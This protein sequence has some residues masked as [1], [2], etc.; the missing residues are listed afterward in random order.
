MK[1][2]LFLLLFAWS[3]LNI[4]AQIAGDWHG[5]LDVKG[6][7]LTIVF[8]FN[9]ENGVYKGTMDSPDQSANGI[10]L[11]SIAFKDSTVNIQIASA[12]AE[13]EGKWDGKL[14]KGNFKQIGMSF[15]LNLEG[16]ALKR[17]RPQEPSAPYPYE[18]EEVTFQNK[19]DS[20]SLAG[21]LTLPKG[22]GQFPSMIM[23]TG[24]G[25]ENRDE[26]IYD[27][28]PFWI[29]ADYLTRKGIAVLRYDDRGFGKSGGAF[30][31]A[32]TS[33]F[34][35]D[36][37]A[38][39]SY[40]KSRK[41]INK[42]KIGLIGHSE[43]GIIASMVASANKKIAFIVL[44]AGPGVT[45]E[46][47]MVQQVADLCADS[48]AREKVKPILN[49]YT[50]SADILRQYPGES[51][52][53]QLQK[54]YNDNQTGIC[55]NLNLTKEQVNMYVNSMTEQFMSPWF[56]NFLFLDP[57]DYLVKVHCP[58]LALNG[59]LDKQVRAEENLNGIKKALQKGGNKSVETIAIPGMNHLFQ[60]C[61]TG[62]LTEYAAIEQT[63]S[64]KALE[65]I[66][67]FIA[68]VTK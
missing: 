48:A 38:A 3:S 25:P 14:I 8:H 67:E 41:D 27:H 22:K 24:S 18:V 66:G 9:S 1:K 12:M 37:E 26:E 55:N 62:Q 54:L 5:V 42:N 59:A 47:I 63:F 16:G 52:R 10:P 32:T 61:K 58:V 15:P 57:A 50:Q 17:N 44:L 36:V 39:V 11:T 7:K 43:G 49:I 56:R 46:K 21:T 29:I 28:K 4:C 2:T 6:T 30:K 60:E 68:S 13:Y 19:K 64:P 65:L 34:A 40:L 23:I 33:D 51:A 35:V 45:G 53:Q 20:I 31:G